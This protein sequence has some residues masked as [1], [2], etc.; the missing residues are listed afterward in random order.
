M[1][2]NIDF[3]NSLLY[4]FKKMSSV[5]IEPNMTTLSWRQLHLARAKLK[6][7]SRTSALL[8][9]FAMVGIVEHFT[10]DSLS[11][12]V[13]VMTVK[14]ATYRLPWLNYK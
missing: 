10:I 11:M 3:I 13:Y 6:A 4:I 9:G 14:F 12:T 7:S 5:N 2:D 8:S 1:L